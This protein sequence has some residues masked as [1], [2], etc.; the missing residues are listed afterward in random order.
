MASKIDTI[1]RV[2]GCK[3]IDFKDKKH[4]KVKDIHDKIMPWRLL[5]ES[6]FCLWIQM[7]TWMKSFFVTLIEF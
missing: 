3:R 4:R 1:E 6:I 5:K 7:I 2:G